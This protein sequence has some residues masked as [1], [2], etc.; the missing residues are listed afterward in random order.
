M[1]RAWSTGIFKQAIEGPVELG[2]TNLAGDEQSDLRLHG[3]PDKAVCAYSAEQ[4][5]YWQTQLSREMT[6]GAFGENFT[7]GGITEADVCIGDVFGIGDSE[8]AA[9]VQISQPRQPCWKLAR[10]WRIKTLAAQVQHTGRTG[11]YFRVLQPGS[12]A[13]G[14]TLRLIRRPHPDWSVARANQI[15][16]VDKHDLELT[17]VLA[18]LPALS[19]NWKANL[20]SRLSRKSSSNSTARLIGPNED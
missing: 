13:A 15:M 11:W 14:T 5:A 17:A 4:Y 6:H 18:A 9:L 16:H 1:E 3:G 2:F 12:V 20:T 7:L 19:A 10:R 8:Q